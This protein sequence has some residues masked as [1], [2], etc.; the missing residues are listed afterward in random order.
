MSKGWL[1]QLTCRVTYLPDE[2][3]HLAR[4]GRVRAAQRQK[5]VCA[6]LSRLG[7]GLD[8][9]RVRAR[10]R[11]GLRL[12]LGLG[13]GKGPRPCRR[14]GCRSYPNPNPNPNPNQASPCR[15]RGC[16]SYPPSPH[17]SPR[18]SASRRPPATQRR[19]LG[20]AGGGYVGAQL[21]AAS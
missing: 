1:Q 13:L 7:G 15:R 20:W 8:L 17:R 11:L 4:G 6:P 18:C 14:R 9:L 5:L 12:G 3:G 21:A 10:A 16:R 2:R 19:G